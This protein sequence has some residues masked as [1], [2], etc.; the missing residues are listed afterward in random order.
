MV[1]RHENFAAAAHPIQ[2]EWLNTSIHRSNVE[3]PQ[4]P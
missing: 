1:W 4:L 2:S 3:M